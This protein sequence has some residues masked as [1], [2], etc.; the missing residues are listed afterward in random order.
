M[1]VPIHWYMFV[2]YLP[3]NIKRSGSIENAFRDW[4]LIAPQSI[5]DEVRAFLAEA[6]LHSDDCWTLY[7]PDIDETLFVVPRRGTSCEQYYREM[8]TLFDEN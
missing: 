6:A 5:K 2:N 3:D 1:I 4:K 7:C 8:L